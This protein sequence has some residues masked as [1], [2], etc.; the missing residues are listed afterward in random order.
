MYD[1]MNNGKS[2]GTSLNSDTFLLRRHIDNDFY[3]Y[4]LKII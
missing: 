4:A 1:I 2:I 3:M